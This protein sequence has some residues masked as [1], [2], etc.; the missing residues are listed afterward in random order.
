MKTMMLK[1]KP[2]PKN[3]LGYSEVRV[4]GADGKLKKVLPAKPG[5]N[6]GYNSRWNQPKATASWKD[7]LQ[8]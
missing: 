7:P 2:K 5:P 6:A 8:Y 4:F 3:N 1:Q